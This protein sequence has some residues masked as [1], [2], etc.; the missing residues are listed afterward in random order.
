MPQP[1]RRPATRTK[2]KYS[3]IRQNEKNR[4]ELQEVFVDFG[5][6][7]DL[8]VVV[9]PNVF[10]VAYQ[11]RLH[12]AVETNDLGAVCDLFLE[13]VKRWDMVDEDGNELPVS[14]ETVDL[15]HVNT[16]LELVTKINESQNPKEETSTS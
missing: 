6:D 2:K 15:M 1:S 4:A 14:P 13:S 7:G 12:Q 3:P 8:T 5:D 11:R 9:D 10:T 16:F